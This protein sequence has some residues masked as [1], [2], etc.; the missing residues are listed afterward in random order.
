MRYSTGRR[1]T[2]WPGLPWQTTK[3]AVSRWIRRH[4]VDAE[5]AG[6]G[7]PLNAVAPGLVRTELLKRLLEDPDTK[8]RIE[9]GSPMPLGGP[10]EPVAAAELLA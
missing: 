8:R 10:Y 5:W 3:R 2:P 1:R 9:A 4:A 7:I 6:A